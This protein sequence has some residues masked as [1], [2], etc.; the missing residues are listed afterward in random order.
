MGDGNQRL[1]ECFLRAPFYLLV[2]HPDFVK[3]KSSVSE[4]Y[5]IQISPAQIINQNL[6]LPEWRIFFVWLVLFLFFFFF[7]S[8]LNAPSISSWFPNGAVSYA[9]CFL[10]IRTHQ[11]LPW[12][13]GSTLHICF[14]SP[15]WHSSF[16]VSYSTSRLTQPMTK[17]FAGLC[18][19]SLALHTHKN[20]FVTVISLLRF[21]RNF[22]SWYHYWSERESFIWESGGHNHGGGASLLQGRRSEHLTG[23]TWNS[24]ESPN[25][26]K[27]NNLRISYRNTWTR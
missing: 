24:R 18:I 8:D 25:C 27:K 1:G 16:I 10:A 15:Q 11:R 2:S 6:N 19:S 22:P 17:Y 12:S 20:Y 21:L 13:N 3:F 9:R 23:W 7:Y 5:I 26:G 14:I 4:S